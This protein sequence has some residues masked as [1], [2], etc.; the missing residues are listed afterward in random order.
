MEETNRLAENIIHQKLTLFRPPY[1][2]TTPILANAI[3]EKGFKAIGWS[4]RSYDTMMKDE[5]ALKIKIESNIKAGDVILLHD[6]QS[7]TANALQTIIDSVR[8]KGF[9]LVRLDQLLNI[10]A[11]D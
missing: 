11:Y 8:D 2:V 5:Q 4:L 6:S 7:V 1:G 9:T 3:R 10:K